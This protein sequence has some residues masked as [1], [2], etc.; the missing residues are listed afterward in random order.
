MD[1]FLRYGVTSG[2]LQPDASAMAEFTAWHSQTIVSKWDAFCN[3]DFY[4]E[5]Q[6]RLAGTMCVAWKMWSSSK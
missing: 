4:D 3:P 5:G 6:I 2:G 1:R